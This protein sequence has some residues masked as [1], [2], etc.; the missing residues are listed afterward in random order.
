MGGG[1]NEEKEKSEREREGSKDGLH[2]LPLPSRKQET[3]A[4]PF[5]SGRIDPPNRDAKGRNRREMVPVFLCSCVPDMI[6]SHH[7]IYSFTL[8]VSS[9]QSTPY[10]VQEGSYSGHIQSALRTP[11]PVHTRQWGRPVRAWMQE[12]PSHR[13]TSLKYPPRVS[14]FLPRRIENKKEPSRLHTLADGLIAVGF[15]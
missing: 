5:T 13:E 14:D 7:C 10:R 15:A 3:R 12:M 4:G 8:H 2:A 6:S 9:T 1:G 11:Y